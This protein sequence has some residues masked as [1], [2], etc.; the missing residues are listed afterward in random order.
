MTTQN[1]FTVNSNAKINLAL[2]ITDRLDN[3]YHTISTLFQEID[4]HDTIEFVKSEKFG[5][6]SNISNLPTDNTN[7]CIAA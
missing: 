5:F 4:F 7:L 1:K 3:G 6:T 2:R